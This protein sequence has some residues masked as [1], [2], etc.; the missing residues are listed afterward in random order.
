[1]KKNE[2]QLFGS[3]DSTFYAE[4]GYRDYLEWYDHMSEQ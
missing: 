2:R 1:M 3:K 4:L